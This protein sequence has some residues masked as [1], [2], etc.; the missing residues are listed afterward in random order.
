MCTLSQRKWTLPLHMLWKLSNK[1]FGTF[2]QFALSYG[3]Y[4]NIIPYWNCIY[5]G[6]ACVCLAFGLLSFWFMH[7]TKEY[8]ARKKKDQV[9]NVCSFNL[10]FVCACVISIEARFLHLWLFNA[11][12]NKVEILCATKIPNISHTN[13]N[14]F[15]HI[16]AP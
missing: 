8:E 10:F 15:K 1:M 14:Q 9:L 3:K 13:T 12:L 4:R 11:K 7:Y 2:R 16:S 6:F 5:F